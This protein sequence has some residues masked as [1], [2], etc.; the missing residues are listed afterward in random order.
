MLLEMDSLCEQDCFSTRAMVHELSFDFLGVHPR[1]G[2]EKV[3]NRNR[4]P[5]G[6]ETAPPQPRTIDRWTEFMSSTAVQEGQERQDG[7]CVCARA[8]ACVCVCDGESAVGVSFS[9]LGYIPDSQGNRGLVALAT[10]AFVML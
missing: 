9:P 10:I 8:R 4:D 2:G 1:K 7:F 6:R 3:Q 5:R